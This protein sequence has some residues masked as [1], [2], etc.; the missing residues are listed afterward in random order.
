MRNWKKYK[1]LLYVFIGAAIGYAYYYFIGCR[2][3]NCPIQS[4]PYVSTLYGALIGG[5]LGWPSKKQEAES[6][7]SK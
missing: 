1:R 7:A 4:N 6:G 2:T 3:G 5:V